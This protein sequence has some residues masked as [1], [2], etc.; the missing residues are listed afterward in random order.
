M[1][2]S[3]IVCVGLAIPL[4]ASCSGAATPAAQPYATRAGGT[5]TDVTNG[6][7]ALADGGALV[8]G[9]FSGTAAFGATI[10]TSAGSGDAFVAHIDPVGV[11]TWAAGAGGTDYED[12]LGLSALPDGGAIVT[13][14]FETTAT[15]G[16]TTLTSSGFGDVFVARIDANGAWTWATRAGGTMGDVGL[17]VSALADGGAIVAGRFAGTATFGATNLTSAGSQDAFVA[18]ISP[19]GAWAWATRAGGAGT[20][21]AHGVSATSDGGGIVAGRFQGSATFGAT[22]LTSAG[23]SDAFVARVDAT[24]AWTWATRAGGTSFAEALYVSPLPDGGAIATGR[25]EGTATFGATTLTSG[26]SY[27]VFVARIDSSGTWAWATRA[28]G[29]SGAGTGGVSALPGGGAIVT[30][31]FNGTATFGTTT[32]ASS[33]FSD[34]YV[35]RISPTGTWT[36]ATRAGGADGTYPWGVSALP[37]GG[38]IVSGFFAGTASFG[39]TDL[40]SLGG[41]DVFVARIG[42]DGSW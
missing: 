14:E 3:L 9:S 28:G 22:V 21:Q 39:A 27:D 20:D 31:D 33:G 25:F 7:S 11:W 26:G 29:T 35:A 15:F 32:L 5:G 34:A 19:D 38:A 18:R 37:A 30:G 42:A 10:L 1:I 8:S 36:W 24:G 13:G 12:A 16:T 41:F 6:V 2:R 23:G 4:L 17:S 40:T